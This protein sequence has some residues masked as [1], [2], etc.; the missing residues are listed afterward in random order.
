M[1]ARYMRPNQYG[2]RRL[3]KSSQSIVQEARHCGSGDQYKGY[4]LWR[5]VGAEGFRYQ[6]RCARGQRVWR[7]LL[8]IFSDSAI[9]TLRRYDL[10]N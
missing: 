9:P 10:S 8:I 5:L 3:Q 7:R 2:L 4:W 6:A 1:N